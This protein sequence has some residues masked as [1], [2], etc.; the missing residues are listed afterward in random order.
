MT[1]QEPPGPPVEHP[2][3]EQPPEPDVGGAEG[4]LETAVGVITE[5]V[6]TLR[7]V[8]ATAPLGWA[9]WLTVVLS[10]IAWATGSIQFGQGFEDV[11]RSQP[12]S[13]PSTPVLAVLGLILG[14]IL[15]L[16]GLVIGTGILKL[17]SLM[18]GG[19]GSFKS[20]FCG[21]AFASVPNIFS[22]PIQ[23]LQFLGGVGGQILGG[24]ISVGISIWVVVLAVIAVRENNAFSTGKAVGAVLLPIAAI[25]LLVFVLVAVIVAV[26]VQQGFGT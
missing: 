22:A 25:L 24:L 21:L 18:F 2:S 7:R 23:V 16:I 17:T 3:L 9:I 13:L 12:F 19:K 8:T 26:A 15:G 20:L 10:A 14:P 11:S 4:L 1:I 5:P 6:S